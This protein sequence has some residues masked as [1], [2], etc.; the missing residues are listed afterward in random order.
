V[1]KIE[2]FI[3]WRNERNRNEVENLIIIKKLEMI[4]CKI[5]IELYNLYP[6]KEEN[7]IKEIGTKFKDMNNKMENI[8][9]NYIVELSTLIKNRNAK[10]KKK[11]KDFSEKKIL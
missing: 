9:N 11:N 8:L 1:D 2:Q 7:Y 10:P 5:I 6:D 4:K 3:K